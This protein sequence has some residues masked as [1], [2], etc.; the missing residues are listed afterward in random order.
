M[1]LP[2]AGGYSLN[3]YIVASE[4]YSKWKALKRLSRIRIYSRDA[5]FGMLSMKDIY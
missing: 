4:L 1:Y 2:Y 3:Y 5:A